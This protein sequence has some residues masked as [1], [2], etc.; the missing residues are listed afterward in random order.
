MT[1]A[2]DSPAPPTTIHFTVHS[3]PG[4]KGYG[5]AAFPQYRYNPVAFGTQIEEI[6]TLANSP[7]TAIS[8]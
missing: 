1:R 4:N 8:V 5:L 2:F 3:G 7:M 6:F